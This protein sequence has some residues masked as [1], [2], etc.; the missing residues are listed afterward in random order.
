M[1]PQAVDP[2]AAVSRSR[3]HAVASIDGKDE[4]D[5]SSSKPPELKIA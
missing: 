5:I 3:H 1:L 2:A 4:R